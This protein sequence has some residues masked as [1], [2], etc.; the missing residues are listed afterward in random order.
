LK[1]LLNPVNRM[2]EGIKWGLVVH[3]V[4]MFSLLT[5]AL[6]IGRNVHSI[7]FVDYRGF[8]G[9]EGLPPGPIGYESTIWSDVSS[10][11]SV[12]AFPLNQWLA[13]G[14]LVRHVFYSHGGLSESDMDQLY[15]CWVIYSMS[16]W[17]I[18]FPCLVY[19]ASV[20]TLP[21]L[22]RVDGNIKD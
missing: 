5:I 1:A 6:A 4:V 13:D 12:L 14:L 10:V 18:A 15:R 21:N 16:Y 19:I 7:S 9:T 2:R 8:P 11:V 3:V 22:L 17:V 20:G